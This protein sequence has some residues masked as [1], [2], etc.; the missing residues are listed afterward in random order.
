M[1]RLIVGAIIAALLSVNFGT[2]SVFAY[3]PYNIDY[4]GG[5]ELSTSNVQIDPEL[6]NSLIPLFKGPVTDGVMG[7]SN[8]LNGYIKD[9]NECRQFMYYT[10][11]GHTDGQVMM[12]TPNTKSLSE[13]SLPY[14]VWANDSYA[15]GVSVL[16]STTEYADSNDYFAFGAIPG[17]DR[18]YGGVQV[19]SDP[20][21]AS[22][23]QSIS[24]LGQND[25][26]IFVEM[27]IKLYKIDAKDV[28]DTYVA[29]D[30]FF[31]IED[32]DNAQSFM[33]LNQDNVLEKSNMYAKSA[34]ALQP[35]S[36]TSLKNRY[37]SNGKYI[38][39]E[40]NSLTGEMFGIDSGSDVYVRLTEETQRNGLDIVFGFAGPAKCEIAFY[41]VKHS[42]KYNADR[43]GEIT[44]ITGEEVL[45]GEHASGS[46]YKGKGKS[47]FLYWIAD[48]DVVLEDG[49]VI[50][51]GEP[52]TDEQ[53]S[54]IVVDKD[55]NFTAVFDTSDIVVPN[56]GSTT[57]ETNA[58]GFT[59]SV[60]GIL[61]VSLF[62]RALPRLAHRRIDFDK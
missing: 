41:G 27:N 49:T 2:L 48:V 4:S 14:F 29:N 31:S 46:S 61:L 54:K 37:S 58:A 55:I 40:Y 23:D 47:K 26:R 35:T 34:A 59:L 19:Y 52:I 43:N 7:D 17:E 44:G 24:V 51:A 12:A 1:K 10:L 50:K 13:A 60:A 22:P 42:I 11:H 57:M 39:S 16:N 28:N 15:I 38:Y 9:G 30:V 3:N 62:I 21:C 5:V 45:P 18:I 25:A 20:T 6:I 53:L 36:G 33:I 32:I 56:T 8:Y